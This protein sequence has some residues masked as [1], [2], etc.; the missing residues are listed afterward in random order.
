MTTA[1]QLV[2]SQWTAMKEP[3]CLVWTLIL[4]GQSWV[5][6]GKT[7]QIS[8]LSRKAIAV[9]ITVACLDHEWRRG[10][11]LVSAMEAAAAPPGFLPPSEAAVLLSSLASEGMPGMKARSRLWPQKKVTDGLSV[12]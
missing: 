9:T 1:R 11:S 8:A 7:E 10:E 6:S 4:E 3:R 5:A 2:G 12:S